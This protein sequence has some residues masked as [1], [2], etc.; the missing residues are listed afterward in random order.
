MGI[1]Q[2]LFR[3]GKSEVNDA[4]DS[5]ED[6]VKMTAEGIRELEGKLEQS[7]KSLAE[8]KASAISA[9]NALEKAKQETVDYENKAMMFLKAAETGKMSQEEADKLATQCLEKKSQKTQ[10]LPVL[11]ANYQKYQGAADKLQD[12]VKVLKTNIDKWKS[13]AKMLKARSKVAEATANLNKQLSGIDSS[14]TIAMLEK[15]KEK[16]DQQEAL[17]DS[18]L[19]IAQD[20]NERDIDSA[21]K[22]IGGSMEAQSDL[23]ALKAKMSETK[24]IESK[25]D[26]TK[27]I[28]NS[29]VS[30]LDALKQKMAEKEPVAN[31]DEAQRP[32]Q[33]AASVE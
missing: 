3:W 23:A 9:K 4:M 30:D 6:P 28:S 11:E 26:E 15:M 27:A 13:E 19:E 33:Q 17:A 25:V 1:F 31:A 8:V 29:S 12:A 2:R 20:S 16:V 32:M 14:D 24:A 7:M 22:A 18:Y 21:L 10:E 5:L